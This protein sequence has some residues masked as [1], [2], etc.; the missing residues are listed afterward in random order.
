MEGAYHANRLQS[1]EFRKKVT[2]L[3]AESNEDSTAE[4]ARILQYHPSTITCEIKRN[5]GIGVI[6]INNGKAVERR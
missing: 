2:N 3:R 6:A 4:I 1:L 5:T